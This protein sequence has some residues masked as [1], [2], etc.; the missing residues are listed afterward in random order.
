MVRETVQ[1]AT[2]CPSSLSPL[3]M[4]SRR[5][6]RNRFY[7]RGMAV[8]PP[9][10]GR[11]GCEGGSVYAFLYRTGFGRGRQQ[12]PFAIADGRYVVFVGTTS[13]KVALV[14]VQPK[15]QAAK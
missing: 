8:V 3:D 5:D 7:S 10:P 12:F 13:V 14:Q 11:A 1:R 9:R 2:K 15:A 4:G 6:C